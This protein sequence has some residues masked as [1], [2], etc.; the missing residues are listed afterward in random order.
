MSVEPYEYCTCSSNQSKRGAGTQT[1]F[2][3]PREIY[4]EVP[5]SA[6]IIWPLRSPKTVRRTQDKD[7]R[8]YSGNG[9]SSNERYWCTK[10]TAILPSPTLLE[11]LDRVVAN[12]TYTEEARKICFQ[13]KWSTIC[14]PTRL[15]AH[16]APRAD[17]AVFALELRWQP[18]GYCIGA[19]H[20]KQSICSPP[21]DGLSRFPSFYCFQAIRAIRRDHL[22][23]RLHRW[24]LPVP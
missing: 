8:N 9:L 17:I 21:D 14:R 3:Q 7:D 6:G 12:V 1:P 20:D 5:E 16:L 2:Q 4:G 22:S 23:F 19:D 10:A 18:I 24:S 15:V 13:Q 11:T